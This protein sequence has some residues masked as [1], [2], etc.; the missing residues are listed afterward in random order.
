[1][2]TNIYI[3]YRDACAINLGISVIITG[4]LY[5]LTTVSQYNEAGYY[6][7][8]DL[9]EG[10]WHHGCSYYDN[11]DGTRVGYRYIDINY[12]P[13]I[14][15]QTLLV[16]GGSGRGSLS[17]TELLVGTASAWVYTGELPSPRYGLRGANIDN[18]V[19]MTGN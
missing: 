5:S 16:T 13:L 1:M 2:I 8:P 9:L 15:F 3:Y 18:R 11:D 7:A 19:I 6:N 10:R 4:G 12:C 14:I 17:S